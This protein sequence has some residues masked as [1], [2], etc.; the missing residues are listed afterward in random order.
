[1]CSIATHAACIPNPT[2]FSPLVQLSWIVL[3]K[4]VFD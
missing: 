1:M 4:L 2:E 3:D